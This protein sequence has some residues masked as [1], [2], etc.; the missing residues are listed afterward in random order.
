MN[1]NNFF[2]FNNCQT[3]DF[4]KNKSE[5]LDSTKNPLYPQTENFSQKEINDEKTLQNNN[6]SNFLQLLNI[7]NSKKMDIPTLL[8]SP[9]GKNLGI[10][11]NL[12][13]VLSLLNNK[14]HTKTQS[15]VQKENLPKIDSLERLK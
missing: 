9:I 2:N 3:Q 10:N 15:S 7:F 6:L 14:T 1:T 4:S 11:E 12:I 5:I 13:S 8:S